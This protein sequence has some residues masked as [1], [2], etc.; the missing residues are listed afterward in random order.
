[1]SRTGRQRVEPGTLTFIEAK[2]LARAM[3]AEA[4]QDNILRI[5]LEGRTERDQIA[6]GTAFMNRVMGMPVAANINMDGGP[7]NVTVR[8]FGE[9]DDAPA[10]GRIRA[11][12]EPDR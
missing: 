11:A 9:D 2:A 7:I 1:M 10:E 6:A 4:V 5:A 8:R 12:A 3:Q